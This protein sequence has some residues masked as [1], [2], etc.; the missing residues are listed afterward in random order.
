MNR[1]GERRSRYWLT[2]GC[3]LAVL[4]VLGSVAALGIFGLSV[5]RTVRLELRDADR[6]RA[7]ALELLGARELPAGYRVEQNLPLWPL[8]EL[9]FLSSS[10]SPDHPERFFIYV[11]TR[12]R[13]GD[14]EPAA[15]LARHG[16][17][18]RA[19]VFAGRGSVPAAGGLVRY[20]VRRGRF[21]TDD[22]RTIDP[23]WIADMDIDCA[24]DKRARYAIWVEAAALAP[25]AV[26]GAVPRAPATEGTPADSREVRRFL[27]A[28]SLCGGAGQSEE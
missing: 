25:P 20:R 19:D 14:D 3:A 6:R 22:G 11:K 21:V 16:F 2:G 28:F 23:A 12:E 17:V 8:A 13:T 7:T 24:A 15:L 9:V 27:S 1:P 26:E 10:E 4:L 18:T 5:M